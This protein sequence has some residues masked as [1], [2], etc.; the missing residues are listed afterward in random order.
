[1]RDPS[2]D[3]PAGS[4]VGAC[5]GCS[6]QPRQ[7]VGV[8]AALLLC[9]THLPASP[10]ASDPKQEIST[11]RS[12]HE[13]GR[14][15]EGLQNYML[16]QDMSKFWTSAESKYIVGFIG[17]DY[18]RFQIHYRTMVRDSRTK[19]LYTLSGETRFWG[20]VCTFTGAATVIAVRF[21][22]PTAP[23]SPGDIMGS[24]SWDVSLQLDNSC[25]TGG[26]IEGVLVSDFYFDDGK[27]TLDERM[28]DADSYAN[29]QCIAVWRSRN[30]KRIERCHWGEHRIPRCGDLD[31]G[32]GVFS[33]IPRY[34]ANGWK[35][36]DYLTETGEH[37]KHWWK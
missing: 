19:G 7:I 23:F 36:Y 20:E 9:V 14:I 33:P 22:E 35:D 6:V 24:V 1:M 25:S 8:L 37:A 16:L 11:W 30:S 21:Y 3:V 27:P 31:G 26:S 5:R 13:V 10:A 29:N 34:R 15:D 28:I 12:E 2:G 4:A 32:A 18:H 17:D